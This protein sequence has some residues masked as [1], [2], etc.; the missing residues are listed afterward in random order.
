MGYDNLNFKIASLIPASDVSS[1]RLFSA[2]KYKS[3]NSVHPVVN[4]R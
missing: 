1:K 3:N 4:V 2:L